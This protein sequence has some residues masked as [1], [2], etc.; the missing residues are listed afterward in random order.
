MRGFETANFFLRSMHVKYIWVQP[1][2]CITCTWHFFTVHKLLPVLSPY[3][4]FWGSPCILTRRFPF[5]TLTHG[6]GQP[7]SCPIMNRGGAKDL[8][9]DSDGVYLSTTQFMA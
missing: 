1:S 4:L 7:L 9:V 8:Q 6:D 3:F 5:T 2:G